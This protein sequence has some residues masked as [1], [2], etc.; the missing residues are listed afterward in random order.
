[1]WCRGILFP[2]QVYSC[3]NGVEGGGYGVDLSDFKLYAVVDVGVGGMG[4]ICGVG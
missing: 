2:R 4:I 3:C 1:M